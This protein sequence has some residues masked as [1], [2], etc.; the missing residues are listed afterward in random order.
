[1]SDQG[2]GP[3]LSV[4]G[5]VVLMAVVLAIVIF[6]SISGSQDVAG[7]KRSVANVTDRSNENSDGE[8]DNPDVSS[9]AQYSGEKHRI[10]LNAG[11]AVAVTG[12]FQHGST[13]ATQDGGEGSENTITYVGVPDGQCGKEA[14]PSDH[15]AVFDLTVEESGTYYPW[16]RVWWK[17]SCGD[18]LMI[19]VESKKG[20]TKEFPITDGTH[21]TWHWLRVAGAS[22][23]ILEEGEYTVRVEN[24]EDGARLDKI[25]FI[26]SDYETFRPTTPQG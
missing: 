3:K 22:G 12:K 14:D 19:R 5:A 1:M 6:G 26:D 21:G 20:G 11:D 17:D 7:K 13:A 9:W 24:R 18:S 25:L 2:T 4:V 16:A 10:V 23:L 8:V 15:S